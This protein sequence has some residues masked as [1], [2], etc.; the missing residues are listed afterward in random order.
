VLCTF[1]QSISRGISRNRTESQAENSDAAA[2][3]RKRLELEPDEWQIEVL[4]SNARRGILNCC[5][6]W[7]KSTIAAAKAVHRAF[8]QEKKLVLVAS[9]SKRQSAEFLRKAAGLVQKLGIRPRGDGDNETS[10]LFPNG[11]RIVGL[12]GSEGTV[13]GFSAVSLLLI[14][15]AA[16][17]EDAMYK[18]LRPMLAVGQ[19]DL[20]LMS[21]PRGKRGFFHES[22]E[23]GG[24]GWLRVR[25]P[26]TDCPRIPREFLEEERAQMGGLWFRQEYLCEFVDSGAGVF[27]RDLVENALDDSVTPLTLSSFGYP[28]GESG[29]WDV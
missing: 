29:P 26:A 13:R 2:F 8:T 16:R 25:V 15:E 3:V 12:P 10:L 6:Q 7:G 19:G 20:W 22:W 11:S 14:D 28:L 4:R 27:Q 24:P 17:V 18:A 21:T 23:H 1:D 9:P 5:R